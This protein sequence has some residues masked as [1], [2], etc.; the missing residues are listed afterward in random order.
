MKK[1]DRLMLDLVIANKELQEHLTSLAD[2]TCTI[3]PS[4]HECLTKDITVLKA[5]ILDLKTKLGQK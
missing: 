5:K 2:G 3:D 4:I 1:R